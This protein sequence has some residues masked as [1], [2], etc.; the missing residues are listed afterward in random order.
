MQIYVKC[1][2]C[3][4]SLGGFVRLGA[5]KNAVVEVEI[6]AC[7]HK[8]NSQLRTRI[9]KSLEL[10]VTD[11]KWRYNETKMNVDEGS[12]GGY[13]PELQAAIDLLD[14]LRGPTI[15]DGT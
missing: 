11:M 13:S 12:E 2:D 14:E 15:E 1:S 8:E 3:K 10:M 4:Q 9:V 6:H 5:G 7:F